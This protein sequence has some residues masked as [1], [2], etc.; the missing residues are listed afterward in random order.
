MSETNQSKELPIKDDSF[1][2]SITQMMRFELNIISEH[3]FLNWKNIIE[4]MNIDISKQNE[5]VTIRMKRYD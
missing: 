3:G 4:I 1:E 5:F 2:R